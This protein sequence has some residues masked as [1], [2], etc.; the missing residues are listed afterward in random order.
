MTPQEM[1][2]HIHRTVVWQRLDGLGIEH[3]SLAPHA[4]GWQIQGTVIHA[5]RGPLLVRYGVTCDALWRTRAV[6][7]EIDTGRSL[8]TLD[9][10]VDDE[11]RWWSAGAELVAFRGCDDVD[12]GIT[13]VTNTL[14]IRRLNLAIGE[15]RA[16][17]AAWVQFPDLQIEPLPQHYTRLD[18]RRYRYESGGG[19]FTTEITVDELG[20]VT[21]YAGGWER[22]ATADRTTES[23]GRPTAQGHAASSDI[24]ANEGMSGGA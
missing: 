6:A 4:D 8:Q 2:D 5:E 17:T 12:L 15:T 10:T 23:V 9:M 21:H 13:P 24:E 20:L 19:A 16:I 11:R 7:I 3:C 22:I 18:A 1:T 14:P